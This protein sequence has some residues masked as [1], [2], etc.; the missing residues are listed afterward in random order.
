MKAS[1]RIESCSEEEIDMISDFILK[2]W[3]QDRNSFLWE[4]KLELAYNDDTSISEI[5]TACES[6]L[7]P[8]NSNST[9]ISQ[10][11]SNILYL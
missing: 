1:R 11:T 5:I 8:N 6:T 10:A 3:S 7:W 4:L 2:V 9:I